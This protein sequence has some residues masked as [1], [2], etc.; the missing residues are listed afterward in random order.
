MYTEEEARKKLMK[1]LISLN[2]TVEAAQKNLCDAMSRVCPKGSI[3]YFWLKHGQ[4]YPSSGIVL[5]CDSN[6]FAGYV[7]VRMH[8]KKGDVRGIHFSQLIVALLEVNP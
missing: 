6:R 5:G 8:S 2:R 4:K 7:R 1:E 3:I